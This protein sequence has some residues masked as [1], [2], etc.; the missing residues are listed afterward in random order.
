MN[1]VCDNVQDCG[2]GMD[3]KQCVTVSTSLET[4]SIDRYTKAIVKF[5][6]LAALYCTKLS[7]D[8]HCLQERG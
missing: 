6:S 8:S 4:V 5:Q 3:E 7:Y 1:L 2:N